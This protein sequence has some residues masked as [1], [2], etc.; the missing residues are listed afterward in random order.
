VPS[1]IIVCGAVWR[2]D[3]RWLEKGSGVASLV[4]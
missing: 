4:A 1:A 3:E 2:H